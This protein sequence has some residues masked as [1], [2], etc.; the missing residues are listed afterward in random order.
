M[1][2]NF[3]EIEATWR[4]KWQ[5][6]EL[7]K[8]SNNSDKPKYYVLDMF[9]YPS[10]AGLH[11]GHPLGYIASDIYSRY[12]RL[13]GFNVLHP[14]GFDAFGLPA[15]QYAIETGQHPRTSTEKNIGYFKEQLQNIGFSYDWSREVSTCDPEYFKWTQWAF[16]QMFH[17][18]YNQ[19]TDQS[20]PID[21]LIAKFAQGG[22]AAA[23]GAGGEHEAFDADGW[24]DMSP[25]D[26]QRILMNYRLMFQAE[27]EVWFCEALGTVLA[28]DEVKDGLSERGGHPVEKKKLRQWF[29]RT[30]AFAE[31][32]LGDL[33]DLNWPESMKEMQR[34]WIGKSYGASIHF[35]IIG[36]DK[37]FEIFTTRADTIFGATFMVLAPEHELV[38]EITTPEQ[39]EKIETYLDYVRKRSERDRLS[40]VKVVTGEFTGA[41]A[42]H[43]F[44]GEPVPIWIAE[45]V[46]ASYGTGAIMAVPSDDDRDNA[47]AE[48]FNIPIVEIID[49]SKY[50]GAGRSDKLGI[51]INSDFLDGMEVPEAIQHITSKLEDMG[52]GKGKINYRLRDAG[53]S[54]QRYWGEPFPIVY[55]SED[56]SEMP[57]TL[58]ETE[59]PLRL[60]EVESYSQSPD[61]RS[62]IAAI[63]DWVE[64]PNGQYR[65]TDTM[66][67]YAGSSWYFLRYMDPQNKGTFVGQDA[68][69]YWKD[70]DLYIGGT[71][72]AVGHLLYS[73]TWHKYF[74]DQ[75]LV[76]TK[77]PF[78]RLVNQGMIQGRS[79]LIYRIKGEN[80]FVSLE[81]KD[82]HDCSPIHIPIKFVDGKDMLDIE[83]LKGWRSDFEEADFVLHEGGF[84]CDFDVEKMSKRLYN[85]TDPND[86]IS[87]YGADTFRLY[88]MFLGPIEDSK[89]WSTKGIEG[90]AKFLKKFWRLFV[91]DEQLIVTDDKA[92]PEELKTLHKTIKK[93]DHD[94][95]TLGMN[96]CVSAF[97]VCVN[98]LTAAKCH[99]R[100]IL[101]PL[102]VL[103]APFAPFVT[104][105]L[106]QRLGNEGSV[107]TAVYPE[108]DEQYLKEDAY[109]YPISINGKMRIKINLPLGIDQ[110]AAQ[111]SVLANEMVQKWI[112]G[113]DLRKFIYVPGRI[114]NIVV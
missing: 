86:V 96:T 35:D 62:P 103:L 36:H 4:Q 111:E 7:Y 73:R 25:S 94:L 89:P 109:E 78:Q 54:R 33:D 9:P 5:E 8:V 20:E 2:Y 68:I 71:E 18:W 82:Q 50:P 66:P 63:R 81:L 110:A 41:Y 114:I 19:E 69:N 37:Q 49:K 55:D 60:P 39:K 6:N 61:G 92:S 77:E 99:K 91:Q 87:K 57:K 43:P 23:K 104:E 46:L 58:P 97:M 98:E 108:H 24:N 72:H 84:K 112:E 51:M 101:E 74:Y 42:K 30:T 107:H 93:V 27:S 88:I 38:A 80:K 48:K 102:L 21:T 28:N 3:T 85:V 11:V 34:N 14:M 113:K 75:G 10:G 22:S 59:L 40:E 16:L 52:I 70:V 64:L 65:E 100:E 90:T 15:E 83:A 44:S 1:E 29:L 31:R 17:A 32:L 56:L 45:Y 95:S 47:F 106:Y 26:Q 12:K 53:F 67:G 76:P 13:K 105:E 79:N